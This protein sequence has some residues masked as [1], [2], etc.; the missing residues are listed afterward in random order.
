MR[1][2]A[3]LT[4]SNIF[5]TF[6]WYGHLKY[7]EVPLYK[8]IVR[9][10]ADCVLRILLPSTGKPH[11][12]LRI[13]R[14]P[15]EDDPGSD[16]SD[17]LRGFLGA[18][19]EAAAALELS[20]GLR[21]DRRGRGR[22]LQEMIF[23]KW[24]SQGEGISLRARKSRGFTGCRNNQNA[25][26]VVEERSFQGLSLMKGPRRRGEIIAGFSPCGPGPSSES[27]SARHD[28]AH[29]ERSHAACDKSRTACRER[30]RRGASR[31]KQRRFLQEHRACVSSRRRPCATP[32]LSARTQAEN[33]PGRWVGTSAPPSL[34]NPA[35][36]QTAI[37][38]TSSQML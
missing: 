10:L 4:I 1:T 5:M 36:S 3:L 14:G 20:G 27:Q 12:L 2:I 22:D 38:N 7:R 23:K 32:L 25:Y 26:F 19:P 16:H 33:S 34:R 31:A 37:C 11:R 28:K 29:A 8:V 17:R 35:P 30:D 24:R 18:V 15:T 13:H 6:A 9:E 21:P